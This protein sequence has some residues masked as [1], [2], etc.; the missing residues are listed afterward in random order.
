M[1]DMKYHWNN[2]DGLTTS[3]LETRYIFDIPIAVTPGGAL[4][5]FIGGLYAFTNADGSV[6]ETPAERQARTDLARLNIY[7]GSALE[8]HIWQESMRT[9]AVSTVRGLQFASESSIP[10]RRFDKNN[11]GQYDTLTDAMEYY[12][13]LLILVR[14]T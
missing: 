5:D 7:A 1:N 8:H 9:D 10:L 12:D 14:Q 13:Q 6:T 3:T 11:I 4:I 2:V